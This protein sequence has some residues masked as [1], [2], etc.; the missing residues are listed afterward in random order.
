MRHVLRFRRKARAKRLKSCII[1][2]C[3][4]YNIATREK[5]AISCSRMQEKVPV[6]GINFREGLCHKAESPE[7][8][9]R[10]Q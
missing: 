9:E 8:S 10:M 1:A 2:A 4:Y 5:K 7:S 6:C 3:G